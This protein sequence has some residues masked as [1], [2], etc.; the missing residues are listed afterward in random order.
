MAKHKLYRQVLLPMLFQALSP[1]LRIVPDTSL[2]LNIYLLN[3]GITLQLVMFYLI[4]LFHEY[5]VE[6]LLCS[7]PSS[8][9]WKRVMSMKGKD[10]NFMKIYIIFSYLCVFFSLCNNCKIS[11]R[12]EPR[13][14]FLLCNHKV[15][16]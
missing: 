14:L 3:E 9:T 4:I 1:P 8:G 12:G 6:N 11:E 15:P 10:P 13:L 7:M 16:C 5:L 2:V